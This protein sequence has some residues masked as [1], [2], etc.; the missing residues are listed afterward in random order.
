MNCTQPTGH[1]SGHRAFLK[2]VC[3]ASSP[4]AMSAAAMS[5]ASR[6]PSAKAQSRSRSCI[7]RCRNSVENPCDQLP[8]A[9]SVAVL[10]DYDGAL[11]PITYSPELAAPSPALVAWLKTIAHHPSIDLRLVTGRPIAV[12]A[13]WFNSDAPV[14]LWAEHG[15][16]FRHA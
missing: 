1:S 15:A 9:G 3:L 13:E 2:P 16:A 4:S 10:V 14:N 8:L 12:V 7:A 6:P 11:V 5:S